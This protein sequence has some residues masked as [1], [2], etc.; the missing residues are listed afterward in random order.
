M[1]DFQ[2]I[3]KCVK[4]FQPKW[5]RKYLGDFG[6]SAVGSPILLVVSYSAIRATDFV[7]SLR[8]FQ[9]K[10]NLICKVFAKHMKMKDQL[11]ALSGQVRIAVGTPSRILKLCDAGAFSFDQLEHV[12]LDMG[13]DA[14]T[15]SFFDIP[16]IRNDFFNL[17][18]K[19]ILARMRSRGGPCRICLY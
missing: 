2:M 10:E 17:F 6:T 12:L 9:T 18:N 19:Y 1:R 3:E 11:S 16:D 13:K 4:R 15:R 5:K 14:K 8:S 7:R